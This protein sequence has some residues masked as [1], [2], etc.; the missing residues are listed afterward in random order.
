[1]TG[2]L[3]TT[4]RQELNI[5]PVTTSVSTSATLFSHEST[6][7]KVSKLEDILSSNSDLGHKLYGSSDGHISTST[8]LPFEINTQTFAPTTNAP[9]I[10][11]TVTS[12]SSILQSDALN[13]HSNT[14][15]EMWINVRIAVRRVLLFALYITTSTVLQLF[16][17]FFFFLI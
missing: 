3:I 5:S 6:T 17:L 8:G 4:A 15:E 14:D 12:V 7:N 16:F 13:H 9:V 11:N 10:E 1:M 2:N